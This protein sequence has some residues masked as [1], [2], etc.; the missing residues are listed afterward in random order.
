MKRYDRAKP[1]FINCGEEACTEGIRFSMSV[2]YLKHLDK[3]T[4]RTLFE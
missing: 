2:K 4:M 3:Q 1:I